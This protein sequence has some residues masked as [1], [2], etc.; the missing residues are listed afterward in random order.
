MLREIGDHSVARYF[1]VNGNIIR[2]GRR[3]Y[4]LDQFDNIYVIG[5]GKASAAMARPVERLLGRRITSGLI[6]VKHGDEAKLRRIAIQQ[7]GHR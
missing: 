3:R 1:S 5:A 4:R 7:C 6:I 2:A